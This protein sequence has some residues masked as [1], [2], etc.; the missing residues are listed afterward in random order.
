[1]KIYKQYKELIFNI[2]T[3][4]NPK[5]FNLEE[6]IGNIFKAPENASLAHCVS[7]DLH[8]GRGIAVQFR[9]RY[10]RIDELKEQEVKTGELAV[11]KDNARYIYYLITKEKYYDKPTYQNLE[12]TLI[13]LRDHCIKHRVKLLCM[14]RIGCEL[15]KLEWK[16]VIYLIRRIFKD[17]KINIRVYNLPKK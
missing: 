15:D 1:M 4:N 2:D 5:F 8:M 13:T 10:G 11:L 6:I 14:P 17:V 12:K 16:R 7:E 3:M 9:K